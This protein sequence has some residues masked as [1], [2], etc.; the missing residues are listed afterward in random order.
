[1]FLG[2]QQLLVITLHSVGR[3][4]LVLRLVVCFRVPFGDPIYSVTGCKVC[5]GLYVIEP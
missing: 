5:A 1:M 2:S 3:G 4:K